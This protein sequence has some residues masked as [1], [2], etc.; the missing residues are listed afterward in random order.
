MEETKLEKVKRRIKD[1]E[2]FIPVDE[3]L[4]IIKELEE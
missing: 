1:W 2:K 3:A 4:A